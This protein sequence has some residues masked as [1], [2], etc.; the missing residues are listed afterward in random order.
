MQSKFAEEGYEKLSGVQ[1]Y[2]VR[3]TTSFLTIGI[4][5]TL[6]TTLEMIT[7]QVN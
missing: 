2:V 1:R 6:L 3:R 7:L 5:D 4:A